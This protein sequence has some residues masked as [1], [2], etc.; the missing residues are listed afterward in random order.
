MGD[1]VVA[2]DV[3]TVAADGS[4][5]DHPYSSVRTADG[6]VGWVSGVLPYDRDGSVVVE[7]DAAVAAVLR[8]L[9]E[10]VSAAGATL[11]DVVK[12]TAYL[13]DLGWRDALNAAWLATFD[14]PRPARTAVEVQA[15]PRGAPIELDAVIHVVREA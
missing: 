12:V 9:D 13:V 5:E 3:R 2:H 7:R 11:G 15:L 10:R 6:A 14:D 1:S 4:I 8:V